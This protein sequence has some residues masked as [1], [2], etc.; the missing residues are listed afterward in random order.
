M[1]LTSSR[2]LKLLG[3]LETHREWT[4]AELAARL[5][6]SGRTVRKDIERLRELGY[7]VD[8]TRGSAGGYRLGVGAIV[9]PLLLDDDEAV[10]TAIGL[11]A[12][13]SLGIAGIED[14][15][16]SALVKLERTLPD[17][18]RRRVES[19]R[20]H[21][22]RVPPDS[23]GPL[24]DPA[25]LQALAGACRTHERQRIAYRRHDR[26]S[27]R[28]M[29]E[30]H[31]VVSWGQRWYLVAW[32]VDRDDWRTFRVDRISRVDPTGLLFKPH[33]L[34]D[35]DITAYIA[36]NVSRAAWRYFARV[37]V[38]APADE[39]RA[40]INP[41]VGTVEPLDEGTCMLET[42]ADDLATIAVYLGALDLDFRVDEPDELLEHLRLLADRYA[43]AADDAGNRSPG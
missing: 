37:T 33:V 18:L 3:L 11:G 27:S 35:D 14:A 4:G 24:T 9:P 25:T 34:P 7:P 39:V 5:G 21:A 16:L 1:I 13:S 15:S 28:R 23:R 29:V 41:A 6:V 30:P 38:L 19:M 32:D 8:A 42:G 26:T 36:R 20:E 10:A 12:A 31:H 40:R 22:S 17:R 2:L 43:R